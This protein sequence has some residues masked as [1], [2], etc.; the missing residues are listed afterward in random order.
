[1][2]LPLQTN[3]TGGA[4]LRM[5][6]TKRVVMSE[7]WRKFDIL[8]IH[9][10]NLIMQQINLQ[11]MR[12]LFIITAVLLAFGAGLSLAA[13]NGDNNVSKATTTVEA[14]VTIPEELTM[15]MSDNPDTI[16]VTV[17]TDASYNKENSYTSWTITD[18]NG[19]EITEN[20]TIIDIYSYPDP[21]NGN[22]LFS[23]KTGSVY[24]TATV[25]LVSEDNDTIGTYTT[26][27]SKITVTPPVKPITSM[28]YAEDVSYININDKNGYLYK[29]WEER[30]P[31]LIITP[32]DATY[33]DVDITLD[34]GIHEIDYS[35]GYD[36][37]AEEGEDIYTASYAYDTTVTA[38][39][40]VIA[41][42]EKPVTEVKFK[43]DTIEVEP[44]TFVDVNEIINVTPEDADCLS[45]GKWTTTFGT[46]SFRISSDDTNVAEQWSNHPILTVITTGETNV[47]VEANDPQKASATIKFKS[48]EPDRTPYDRYQ[49]GPLILTG[50]AFGNSFIYDI[51]HITA[52]STMMYRVFER[53]NPNITF[54]RAEGIANYGGKIYIKSSGDTIRTPIYHYGSSIEYTGKVPTASEALTV[55]DAKT[56]KKI[57]GKSEIDDELDAVLS[58]NKLKTNKYLFEYGSWRIGRKFHYGMLVYDIETGDTVKTIEGKRGPYELIQSADGKIWYGANIIDPETFEVNTSDFGSIVCADPKNNVVFRVSDSK[59]LFR[60]DLDTGEET[61]FFTT[62]GLPCRSN[63]SSH[64]QY[65]YY[66]SAVDPHSGD[67]VITTQENESR[68][69]YVHIVDGVT[70]EIKKTIDMRPYRWYGAMIIFPDTY[71]PEFTPSMI[72]EISLN[73]AVPTK[74]ASLA[75]NDDAA[76]TFDLADAATDKDNIDSNIRFSLTD[77]GDAAIAV[78]SVSGHTLSVTPMAAGDTKITLMAE[79]NGLTVSKDIAIKVTAESGV[80]AVEQDAN[81]AT[82]ARYTVAGQRI[83]APQKGV[84]ILRTKDG[85]AHKV[86]VK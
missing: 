81:T 10:I 22:I 21:F 40:K 42:F 65:I 52:D 80:C 67:V 28:R 44:F 68:Y 47:T 76:Y 83:N 60:H 18:E 32:A 71:A 63:E 59:N 36:S 25:T 15:P 14:T 6:T 48:K 85:K 57:E 17:S 27:Q 41:K 53:E 66:N 39:Y 16:K 4:T 50:M 86:A 61:L 43:M 5:N 29:N 11:L 73:L 72:S 38:S 58:P 8:I 13:Y 84:N 12:R 49:D 33:T 79:S 64:Y 74:A 19:T 78:A 35:S 77:T 3:K 70:G 1:M 45:F 69:Q 20:N 56:L 30:L 62:E 2:S 51:N 37:Y 82:S 7:N 54:N 31:K 9:Q 24:A 55:L 46:Y 34:S 23:G 26:N 75:P